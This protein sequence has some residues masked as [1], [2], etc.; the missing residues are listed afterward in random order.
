MS[1]L[2][3]RFHPPE[4]LDLGVET[5]R[6]EGPCV[7][8]GPPTQVHVVTYLIFGDWVFL[9]R[10]STERSTQDRMQHRGPQICKVYYN[11]QTF[12]VR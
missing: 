5:R 3:I 8:G 7:H 9:G 12:C 2:L 11:S 4:R 1:T 10:H 6:Y